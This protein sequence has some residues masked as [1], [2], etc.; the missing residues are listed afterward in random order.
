M[1]AVHISR[2]VNAEHEILL[3]RLNNGEILGYIRILC[4]KE[5]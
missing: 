4:T 2:I 1:A 3:K 5:N